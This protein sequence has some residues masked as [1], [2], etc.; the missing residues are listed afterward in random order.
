MKTIEERSAERYENPIEP[1]SFETD[2]EQQWYRCGECDG[3]IAGAYEQDRIAR[4]EER[5]RCIQLAQ[6]VHCKIC[7]DN[8]DGRTC[9]YQELC[10]ELKEI[11]KAIEEE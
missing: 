7:Q 10:S 2:R 4:N 6:D 3:Y 1:Y 5:E 11:R 8:H 9:K